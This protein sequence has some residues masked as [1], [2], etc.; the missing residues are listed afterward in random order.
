MFYMRF[1][2]DAIT[3]SGLSGLFLCDCAA[4]YGNIVVPKVGNGNLLCESHL[5]GT[6]VNIWE[7]VS[8]MGA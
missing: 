5:R 3:I 2:Y 1:H 6:V 8:E 4:F 7:S